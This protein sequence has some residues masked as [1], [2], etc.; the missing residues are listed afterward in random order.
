MNDDDFKKKYLPFNE[1]CQYINLNQITMSRLIKQNYFNGILIKN[2]VKWIPLADLDR[3]FEIQKDY[4]TLTDAAKFLGYSNQAGLRYLMNQNKLPMPEKF[5]NVLKYKKE[6]IYDFMKKIE[7]EKSNTCSIPEAIKL[8]QLNSRGAFATIL[9]NGGFPN[10]YKGIFS[11]WRIPYADINNYKEYLEKPS[12][13]SKKI[14]NENE[15]IIYLNFSNITNLLTLIKGNVFSTA[16]KK[17]SLWHITKIELD[18]YLASIQ[19][20]NYYS[21]FDTNIDSP[22]NTYTID[23]LKTKICIEFNF[24]ELEC[25]FSQDDHSENSFSRD[26]EFYRVIANVLKNL[27]NPYIAETVLCYLQFCRIQINNLSG[28]SFYNIQR[29]KGFIELFNKL[30]KFIDIEI[31]NVESSKIKLLVGKDSVLTVHQ[32]KIFSK[33]LRFYFDTNNMILPESISFSRKPPNSEKEIYTSKELETLY[34]HALNYKIHIPKAILNRSYSNMW[35]YVLLLLTDFIRGQDIILNVPNISFDETEI[36]SIYWIQ[37]NELDQKTITSIINQIYSAFRNKRTCKTDELLTFVIS[38]DITY[39][40]SI[41]LIISEF[42]RRNTNSSIQLETFIEGKYKR[43][44]TE[45]KQMHQRFFKEMDGHKNFKFQSQKLNNS[46]STY[47]FYSIVEN[48]G[49]DSD[50]A[51]HLTQAARSHKSPD[52]TSIYIQSTNKDGSINKVAYNLFKRGHFGWLYDYLIQFYNQFERKALNMVEKTQLIE[53]IRNEF[54]LIQTEQLAEFITNSVSNSLNENF[55][56]IYDSLIKNMHQKRSSVVQMISK[57]TKEEIS[58][59][60]KKLASSEQ[61]S[62]DSN[63]Q[64]LIYPKCKYPSMTSCYSCEYIIPGNL[65]LIQLNTIISELIIDIEKLENPISLIKSSKFL[66]DALFMWKE[67]RLY[68]GDSYVDSF[69]SLKHTKDRI[70]QISHKISITF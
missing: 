62:K 56:T 29:V 38:P 50:L 41:S 63:A 9:A 61:P 49:V 37:E 5:G 70:E 24:K 31:H 18:S 28:T 64:C 52:S 10:A 4:F 14:L 42:H 2:G 19:E 36:D 39:S 57:Y 13:T 34:N 35:V 66:L 11:N 7:T 25:K 26:F 40:L 1:A 69:I 21:S 12:E 60:I 32:R 58:A 54:S 44:R 53:S 16:Y 33:F 23:Q 6:I 59:I 22:F 30:I 47:L 55:E 48:D 51:L 67:A 43:T 17:D 68:F 27:T 65:F 8:L 3:Y 15:A 20:T 45:G 46:V